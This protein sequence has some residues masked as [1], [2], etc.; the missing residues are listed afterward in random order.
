VKVVVE[1]KKGGKEEGRSGRGKKVGEGR[2]KR[3]RNTAFH[4]SRRYGGDQNIIREEGEPLLA[5]RGNRQRR[6]GPGRK[7]F[8]TTQ[9]IV[10][11]S[12]KISCPASKREKAK[13]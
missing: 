10:D 11:P 12:R 13:K 9:N 5:M 1:K 3:Q 6:G 7:Y 2:E 4:H 8:N